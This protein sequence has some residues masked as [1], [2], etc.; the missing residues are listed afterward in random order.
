MNTSIK[1]YQHNQKSNTIK[2]N[3]LAPVIGYEPWAL[4]TIDSIKQ[5]I[6]DDIPVLIR[7]HPAADYPCSNEE[8]S[9]KL[10][11]ESHALLIV[12]YDDENQTFDVVDPWNKEWGGQY[13]GIEK[14][15]YE[16]IPITC[17][18]ASYGK[19]TIMALP[20]VNI[21]PEVDSNYKLMQ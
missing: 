16:V 15:P 17:V 9:Y 7:V 12:G 14:I 11:M 6:C 13:G 20:K 1:L 5:T 3:G 2:A 8:D 18:N 10:D 21:N 19:K 4:R